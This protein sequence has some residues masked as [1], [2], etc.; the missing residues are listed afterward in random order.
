MKS[1]AV[2]QI[3]AG[4]CF[5]KTWNVDFVM[6]MASMNPC[7]SLSPASLQ[8][9]RKKVM[10]SHRN[11][12]STWAPATGPRVAISCFSPTS[13]PL[14]QA[15]WKAP[16]NIYMVQRKIHL[17]C[18]RS[19][20]TEKCMIMVSLVAQEMPARKAFPGFAASNLEQN[21]GS[22]PQWTCLHSPK[23]CAPE[24]LHQYLSKLAT[25]AH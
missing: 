6:T 3:R 14:L 10:H 11:A 13:P 21:W 12:T 4:R 8:E 16:N 22:F 25:V 5:F 2:F 18:E 9:E 20:V 1:E 15:S 17:I 7:P 24:E 23:W 19:I